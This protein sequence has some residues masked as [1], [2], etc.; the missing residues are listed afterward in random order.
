MIVNRP[1]QFWANATGDLVQREFW[2]DGEQVTVVDTERNI[3]ARGEAPASMDET[4]DTL[5][6]K[7]NVN[8]PLAELL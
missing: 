3:Y 5:I 6:Q 1:N 2:Y 7:L 4:L 8:M